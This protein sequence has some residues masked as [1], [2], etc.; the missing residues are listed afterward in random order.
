MPF[1]TP[2]FPHMKNA[3]STLSER[4]EVVADGRKLYPW[5][6]SIGISKGSIESV[7]KL[8]GSLGGDSLSLMHRVENVRIDWLL[9]GRGTPYSVNVC[10]SD[11]DAVEL[12]D[13]LLAEEWRAYIVTDR[14]RIAI[15]LE[16][17]GAFKT[18]DGKDA[19]GV[20][21]WR[22]VKYKI[23]EVIAGAIGR[24]S[25]QR[26]KDDSTT[27]IACVIEVTT[28]ILTKIEKGQI[29]T[30]R[31]FMAPQPIIGTASQIVRPDAF[32]EYLSVDGPPASTSGEA[33][34]LQHYRSMTP[35]KRLAVNQLA[36]AMT[37]H[38]D[39]K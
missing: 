37:E 20:Q 17:D 39:K 6:K 34:L 16:Q 23:V 8:G 29:G 24:L 26:I 3:L 22:T 32:F 4:L 7:M 14:K 15:V 38:D 9:E 36:T 30:Y 33:Q 13:E 10:L 19:E 1:C 25:I 31:M 2:C 11:E 18:K 5:A 12:I 27:K 28:D 21:Q 35:A